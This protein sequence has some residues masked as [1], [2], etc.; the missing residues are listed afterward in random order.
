M[1]EL[2]E[3]IDNMRTSMQDVMAK[4]EMDFLTSYKSH[5][6]RVTKELEKYKKALNE[7]E[8]LSRREDRLVKLQA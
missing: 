1:I 5:M 6:Y 3:C 8:F 4:H 2:D 7:K